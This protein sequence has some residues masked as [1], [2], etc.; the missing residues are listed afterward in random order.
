[1]NILI[2]LNQ[3][4]SSELKHSVLESLRKIEKLDEANELNQ[5]LDLYTD[6]IEDSH[7]TGGGARFKIKDGAMSLKLSFNPEFITNLF[8]Y[9]V[10]A[11]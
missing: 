4:E 5:E 2:S 11:I 10:K 3:K 6:S 9:G 8:A 1:M 7:F